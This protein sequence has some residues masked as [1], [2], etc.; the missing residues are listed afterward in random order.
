MISEIKVKK[1]C[2]EDITMIEHYNEAISDN[3]Q[4][5]VCHHRDEIKILPSGIKVVRTQ[6]ELKDCGRYYNCPA[7]ELI[8]MTR[9]EHIRLHNLNRTTETKTKMKLKHF[10]RILSEETKKKISD[11]HK[12]IPGHWAGK[13]R[14]KTTVEKMSIALKGK[15][16]WNKGKP[17]SEETKQKIREARQK[18]NEVRDMRKK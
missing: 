3:T 8:F 11:S 1:Y 5:W 15:I 12:G 16:P 14:A 6:Q 17:W 18:Q 2:S 9:S 13:T 10:G 7:T 4:I